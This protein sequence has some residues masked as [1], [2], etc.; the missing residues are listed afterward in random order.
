MCRYPFGS[1]GNRVCT[2]PPCRPLRWSSATISRTKSSGAAGAEVPASNSI[3]QLYVS[4]FAASPLPR[5]I[6]SQLRRF[7]EIFEVM[8]GVD[9]LDRFGFDGFSSGVVQ[10]TRERPEALVQFS[11]EGGNFPKV[12]GQR[13]L[14][15]GVRDRRKQRNER[16]GA[17]QQD[18]LVQDVLN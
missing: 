1:G 7:G 18:A 15:S 6:R 8:R 2:R 4:A 5:D 14:P 17:R 10:V 12:L 3:S 11:A 16:D 9:R 13:V